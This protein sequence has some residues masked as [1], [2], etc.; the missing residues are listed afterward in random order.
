MVVCDPSSDLL[1]QSK[2]RRATQRGGPYTFW[3]AVGCVFA[4]FNLQRSERTYALCGEI[5][6]SGLQPLVCGTGY[7]SLGGQVQGHRNQ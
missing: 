6:F 3:P 1:V 7:C 4:G 5:P 2:L